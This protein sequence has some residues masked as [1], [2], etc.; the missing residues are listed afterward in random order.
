MKH[1]ILKKNALSL[2]ALMLFSVTAFAQ[3]NETADVAVDTVET[4][5]IAA[6][7]VKVQPV[8]AVEKKEPTAQDAAKAVTSQMKEHLSLTGD[9]NT[10]VY[11]VNLDFMKKTFDNNKKTD[12]AERNKK[13]R[14]LE[15][16]RDGKLKSVLND[17]QFKVFIANRGVDRKRIIPFY[18]L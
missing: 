6:E 1:S 17:K 9:Q 15:E 12:K 5:V 8:A 4:I 13:Q 14:G 7:P 11:I 18:T 2:L 3:D 16:E 10:K